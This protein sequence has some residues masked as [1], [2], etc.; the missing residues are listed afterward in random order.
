M[1]ERD[2]AKRAAEKSPL[3]WSVYRLLRNKVTKEKVAVQSHYRQTIKSVLHRS[4]KYT[5]PVSYN[6]DGK[7]L[8][9]EGGIEGVSP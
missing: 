8:T 1:K 9:K 2:L 6:I 5:R 3:K 7:K 4:S